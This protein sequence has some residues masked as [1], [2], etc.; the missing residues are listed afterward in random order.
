ML[1]FT[2]FWILQVMKDE[3]E[4]VQ[5]METATERDADGYIES[6]EDI[7]A[8]KEAAVRGLQAELRRFRDLRAGAGRGTL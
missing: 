4:L 1:C 3:M 8:S 7:L 6:L 5:T 2:L